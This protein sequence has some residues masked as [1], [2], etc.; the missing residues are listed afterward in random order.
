MILPKI[1][2]QVKIEQIEKES[3]PDPSN[4][5]MQMDAMKIEQKLISLNASEPDV[6]QSLFD[7]FKC[8]DA[9]VKA[10][11][12]SVKRIR[13]FIWLLNFLMIIFDVIVTSFLD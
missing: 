12:D 13:K 2:T 5:F 10:Q 8:C 11:A 7:T 6:R 9:V 1:V 3:A 4:S